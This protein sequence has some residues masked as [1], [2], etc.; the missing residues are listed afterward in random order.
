VSLLSIA[1]VTHRYRRGRVERVALRDVSLD[2]KAGELVGVRGER[3]SGR[4]T[5]LRIAAGIELP[6][7]GV[8]SFEGRDLAR[9]RNSVLGTGIGYCQTYVSP[10]E[11]GLV[12]EH[13]AGALLAQ[14]VT[15]R[16]ARRRAEEMLARV[17]AE[18]C[19]AREPFELDGA[20]V[21]RVAIARALITEPGL[22][23]VDE[24]TSGVGLLQRDPILVVLRSV[25]NEGSAVLVCTGDA[26][27]LTG[28]DHAMSIENGELRGAERSADASVVPL[29]RPGT[30]EHA[31]E[32][33]THAQ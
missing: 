5:L 8:V 25:A 13:V 1:N 19:A 11:G 6:E 30:P 29:R 24:P 10:V 16:S 15:L 7:E 31:A 23:V 32:S 9:C 28:V 17:G 4:S 14:R 33:G 22:L 27:D 21:V 26:S 3:R 2:I 18:D 20:E 12:V